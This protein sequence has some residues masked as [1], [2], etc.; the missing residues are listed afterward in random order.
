MD[1]P[2]RY[3]MFLKR[4]NEAMDRDANRSL[5]RRNLTRSQAHLLLILRHPARGEASMKEL[6]RQLHAAQSTVAGLVAR[7][8]R[9]GLVETFPDPDDRRAKRVRLTD[10]GTLMADACRQD[11]DESNRQLV[12]SLRED[13]K[14]TLLTLLER[15]CEQMETRERQQTETQERTMV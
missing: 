14:E 8:E 10:S 11:I 15:V 6:E 1:R 3:G 7:T 13:E 5:Q 4:I 2:P 9:K 12:A